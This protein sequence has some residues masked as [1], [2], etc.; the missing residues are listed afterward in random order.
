MCGKLKQN[1]ST[2]YNDVDTGIVYVE[3]F[4]EYGVKINDD[5]TSYVVI[6]FCPWCGKKLPNSQREKWF[7]EIEQLGIEPWSENVP[8]KYRTDKWFRENASR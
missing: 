5:G 1:S 8:E 7:D 3:K 6:K 4:D 2:N